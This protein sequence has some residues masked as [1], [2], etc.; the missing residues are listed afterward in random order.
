MPRQRPVGHCRGVVPTQRRTTDFSWSY[1]RE[2]PQVCGN[3]L[4][5]PPI[6]RAKWVPRTTLTP[7]QLPC[8]LYRGS[9]KPGIQLALSQLALLPPLLFVCCSAATLSRI[10]LQL[11][12]HP[13]RGLRRPHSLQTLASGNPSQLRERRSLRRQFAE[14]ILPCCCPYSAIP[15]IATCQCL[16]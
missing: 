8:R 10:C 9:Q 13:C 3:L 1:F 15:T 2:N 14:D 5:T 6:F 16:M 4:E 12:L 7:N 11:A